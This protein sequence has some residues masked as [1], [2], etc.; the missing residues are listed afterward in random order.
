[1]RIQI[2]NLPVEIRIC[3][4]VFFVVFWARHGHAPTDPGSRECR[5]MARR[6]QNTTRWIK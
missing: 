1:M 4:G 5:G 2:H 6:A 3:I